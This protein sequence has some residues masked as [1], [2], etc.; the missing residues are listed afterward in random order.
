MAAGFL[1][2]LLIGCGGGTKD[3]PAGSAG[4]AKVT[5]LEGAGST[6]VGPLMQVWATE[7]KKIKGIE[8]NYQGGGSGNGVNKMTKNDVDFGCTD[9][10]MSDDQL[11]TAKEQGGDVVHIPLAMGAVVPAYNLDDLAAPV[12]FSGK[13]LADIYLGKIKKWNDPPLR[14]LNPGVAMPD[15]GISVTRRADASGTSYIWTDFLNKTNP[16]WSK[17]GVGTSVDW[18]IGDGEKGNDGVANFIK[19]TKGALGY[20]ELIYAL[21]TKLPYGDVQNKAGKFIH[22]SLDSVTAAAAAK[23]DIPDDLRYTITNEDGDESYPISGTVFA[24]TYVKSQKGEAVR[25]FLKWC[26]HAG[27]AEAAKLSYAKLPTALVTRI[28]GKLDLIK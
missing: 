12:K 15:L 2:A 7:Y 11:K 27:Q 16:E 25:D 1:S 26:T 28:D 8:V 21:E 19:K 24:V 22:P 3:S 5:K 9:A 20:V 17:V 10:A 4:G 23:K 6:F 18:P 14:D 13:V